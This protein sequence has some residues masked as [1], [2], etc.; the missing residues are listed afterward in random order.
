MISL[1][2]Y[3]EYETRPPAANYEATLAAVREMVENA[4]LRPAPKQLRCI[5]IKSIVLQPIPK[6]KQ[7]AMLARFTEPGE[8]PSRIIFYD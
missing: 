5:P 7:A 1:S 6:W 3:F 4:T 2:S 8:T